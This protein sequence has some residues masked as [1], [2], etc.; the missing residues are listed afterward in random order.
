MCSRYNEA[1]A[2]SGRGQKESYGFLAKEMYGHDRI[3][4]CIPNSFPSV[5]VAKDVGEPSFST[6]FPTFEKSLK[7][8]VSKGCIFKKPLYQRF[9]FK[10]LRKTFVTKV[11]LKTFEGFQI[12]SK[13]LQ[14][15]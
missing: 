5:M 11:L 7:T 4:V 8:F 1:E 15:F 3:F 12:V 13:K 9:S 14:S 10:N 2:A 6:K